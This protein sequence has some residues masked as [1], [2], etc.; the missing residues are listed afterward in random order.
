MEPKEFDTE[1]QKRMDDNVS[2]ER[3]VIKTEIYL[4]QLVGNG[5]EG[6]CA[7]R[8]KAITFLQKTV[9]MFMGGSAVVVLLFKAGVITL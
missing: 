2:M 8:G 7:K 9:F 5:Q 3:R 1:V 6:T 4:E